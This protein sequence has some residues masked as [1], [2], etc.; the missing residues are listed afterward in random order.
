LKWSEQAGGLTEK[1]NEKQSNYPWRPKEPLVAE[2]DLSK[3]Q[4]LADPE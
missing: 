1:A 2:I 3:I 4:T